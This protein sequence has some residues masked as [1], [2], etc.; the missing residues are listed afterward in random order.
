MSFEFKKTSLSGLLLVTPRV[1]PDTRGFFMESYKST[2]F[3]AGGISEEFVQDN[4]S[5]SAQG[6]LR[7]LH[8]QIPPSAQGKL[9]RVVSGKV[10]DVAVDIRRG[11]PTFG[12]WESFELSEENHLMLWVPPGFAHGFYVLSDNADVTYKTTAEYS[13]EDERGIIWNDPGIG[14]KWPDSSPI[15]SDNDGGHPRLAESETGF[16]YRGESF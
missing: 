1:F 4:H 10:F 16:N 12:K 9:V 6:V 2:E 14:I 3:A 7:G 11:S 13:Q 8:Y 5:R 15:L